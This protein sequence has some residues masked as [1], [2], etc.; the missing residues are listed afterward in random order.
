M[1]TVAW[2]LYRE[3]ARN[4]IFSLVVFFGVALIILSLALANLSIG[5][6]DRIVLDFGL[7]MMEMFGVLAVLYVGS[8]ILFQEIAG[9]TVYLLFSKP[10]SRSG[11]I[12][13]KTLGFA[14][15]LAV[16][17]AIEGGLLASILAWRSP[18]MLSW[19]FAL[20]LLAMYLKLVILFAVVLFFSVFVSPVVA[21][22]ATLAVYFGAHAAYPIIEFARLSDDILLVRIAETLAV[23]LPN[24]SGL[25]LKNAIL[26]PAILPPY[27]VPLNLLHGIA[28]LAL[29]LAA[30]SLLFERKTFED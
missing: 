25:N 3:L 2:S 26:W 14:A 29:V 27:S 15:V 4:K 16:I 17:F 9:R 6:N 18:E 21:M 20:V 12:L 30:A 5:N 10:L 13:G 23:I 8:Q 24:F 19:F 7:A 11:Y 22:I 28:Y 1:L